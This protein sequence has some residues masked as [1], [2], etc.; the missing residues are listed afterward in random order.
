ML[1]LRD[2]LAE[3][4]NKIRRMLGQ[5]AKSGFNLAAQQLPGSMA[6]EMLARSKNNLETIIYS[7]RGRTIHKWTHYPEIYERH[8]SGFKSTGVRMLEIGVSK[9]GSLEL[10]RKYF[11]SAATIF[12]ID[13]NPECADCVE[14][15]NQVRIGSQADPTFLKSVIEQMGTPDIILDDGSHV[16]THQEVSFKTLF[17]LLAEGGLYIIEDTHTSYWRGF[18]KGGFK[19][20]GTALELVKDMIDDMHAW[21]HD[22][23]PR[24]S[25]KTEF[26]AIHIYDSVV[27]IEKR[28]RAAPQHIM[29]GSST[30]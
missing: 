16:S 23:A 7:H 8:L 20:K 29:V 1:N 11:G 6:D 30:R 21:Y 24:T 27:V 2:V 12:G 14:A 10:W 25:A 4:R 9:G 19:R 22:H 3:V 18:F 28:K 26:G 13:I 15:P 17:P 5:K